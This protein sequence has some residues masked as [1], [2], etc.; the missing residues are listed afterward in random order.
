MSCGGGYGSIELL[1]YQL[2]WLMIFKAAPRTCRQTYPV[3]DIDNELDQWSFGVRLKILDEAS[4]STCRISIDISIREPCSEFSLDDR[5]KWSDISP[6][7]CIVLAVTQTLIHTP[8][9]MSRC[10]EFLHF[11]GLRTKF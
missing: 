4:K 7:V 8:Q 6:F 9:I 1:E 10:E 2:L 11:Y 5:W 3:K